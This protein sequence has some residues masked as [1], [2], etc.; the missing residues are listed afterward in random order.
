MGAA[1]DLV[2]YSLPDL[3]DDNSASTVRQQHYRPS[4]PPCA[5]RLSQVLLLPSSRIHPF[6]QRCSSPPPSLLVHRDQKP[7]SVLGRTSSAACA[8]STVWVRPRPTSLVTVIVLTACWSCY[9]NT[10]LR[11][12]PP[13]NG[14][15][16]TLVSYDV[17][18]ALCREGFVDH[19]F[20]SAGPD[21][22]CRRKANG[23]IPSAQARLC[24]DSPP[25]LSDVWPASVDDACAENAQISAV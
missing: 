15:R 12:V 10:G 20:G 6:S 4:P 8:G 23:S 7:N 13:R 18:F 24:G 14:S 9:L 5:S 17:L 3:A 1:D 21:A 19:V 16:Y 2:T 25:C 11:R 22:T